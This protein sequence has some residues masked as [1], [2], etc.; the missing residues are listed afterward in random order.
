MK[1]VSYKNVSVTPLEEQIGDAEVFI[2]N[3]P[4][5]LVQ[6]S[7]FGVSYRQFCYEGSTSFD[8]AAHFIWTLFFAEKWPSA[9]KDIMLDDLTDNDRIDFQSNIFK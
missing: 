8:N 1:T 6:A 4:Y 2:D 7:E 3:K 9:I 5:G